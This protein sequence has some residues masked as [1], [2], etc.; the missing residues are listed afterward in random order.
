MSLFNGGFFI[1]TLTYLLVCNF[2]NFR[3]CYFMILH[4]VTINLMHLLIISFKYACLNPTCCWP[5]VCHIFF[6]DR[7]LH[8][9]LLLLVRIA[10][11]VFGEWTASNW[12]WSRNTCKF[13]FPKYMLYMLNKVISYL[14]SWIVVYHELLASEI[15]IT[16]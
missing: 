15:L 10:H 11:V 1:Q 3:W 13:V 7:D 14:T 6:G 12:R 2:Y 8:S 5:S 9:L 4:F 16:N